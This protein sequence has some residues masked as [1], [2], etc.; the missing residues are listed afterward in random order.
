MVSPK[1]LQADARHLFRLSLGH[2]GRLDP[3]RITQILEILEAHPPSDHT[4]L[5]RAWLRLVRREFE[6]GIARIEHAGAVPAADVHAIATALGRKSGRPVTATLTPNPHLLAGLRVRLG[7]DV[8]DFSASGQL[9]G[10]AAA[11][12]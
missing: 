4:A 2:D 11:A 6:R 10:I 7:D 1:R 12:P 5:L 3:A 8:Y 9:A